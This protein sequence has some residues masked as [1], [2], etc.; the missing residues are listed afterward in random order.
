M[1]RYIARRLVWAI[2][3]LLVITFLV[4]VALRMGTDPLKAYLRVNQRA[5]LN[6]AS[7]WGSVRDSKRLRS[8]NGASCRDCGYTAR[9]SILFRCCT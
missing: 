3:T 1:L 2:P 7:R 6:A 4:Y 9:E 8:G 5:R